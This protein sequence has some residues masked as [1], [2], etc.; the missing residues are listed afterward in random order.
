MEA[1]AID[2]FEYGSDTKLL[3][4]APHVMASI[5]LL[6]HGKIRIVPETQSFGLRLKEYETASGTWVLVPH[7]LFR[8]RTLWTK[9]V[10]SIDMAEYGYRYLTGD[11]TGDTMVW[12]NVQA[13]GVAGRIDEYRT[14]FGLR[15]GHE[16]PQG[17]LDGII[18]IA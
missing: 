10:Y 12:T 17:V 3:M 14:Y 2:M 5:N 11:L 15:R 18:P 13:N 1:A 9:R 8:K 16:E 4:G 6:A 7:P